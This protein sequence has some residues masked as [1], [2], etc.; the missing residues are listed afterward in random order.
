[1]D[2]LE[3]IIAGTHDPLI[4]EIDIEGYKGTIEY[5]KL[6]INETKKYQRIINKS[7]GTV[8]TTERNGFRQQNGQEAVAQL[9]IAESSDA[10]YKAE[11]YL[12]RTSLTIDGEETLDEK[13]ITGMDSVL[14]DEIVRQLKKANNLDN[15]RDSSNEVKKS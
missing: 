11:V 6:S 3:R 2:L 13:T 9:N 5:R 7:L 8:S 1:M 15:S 12:V 4:M 14:F 10:E